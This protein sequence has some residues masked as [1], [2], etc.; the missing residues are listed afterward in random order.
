MTIVNERHVKCTPHWRDLIIT[1]NQSWEKDWKAGVLVSFPV[2]MIQYSGQ[3]KLMKKKCPFISNHSWLWCGGQGSRSLKNLI[4]LYYGQ[5]KSNK[6]MHTWAY[7]A[8][9]LYSFTVCDHLPKESLTVDEFLTLINLIKIIHHR[10]SH[11][12]I[13]QVILGFKLTHLTVTISP[14]STWHLNSSFLK[15]NLST[16]SGP[17]YNITSIQFDIE[18]PHYHQ[19]LQQ[20]KNPMFPNCE[21]L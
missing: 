4:I 16:C 9:F 5:K 10:H 13:S 8:H 20:Y 17:S 2:S 12:P 14:L 3:G 6:Q 1:W 11:T 18:S 21:F 7:T 15:H 19:Q